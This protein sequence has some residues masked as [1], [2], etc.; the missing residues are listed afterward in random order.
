[1]FLRDDASRGK[2]QGSCLLLDDKRDFYSLH[3]NASKGREREQTCTRESVTAFARARR[4]MSLAPGSNRVPATQ[5]RFIAAKSFKA[6]TLLA[7]YTIFFSFL[8]L[9]R[10]NIFNTKK[11]KTKKKKQK[12]RVKIGI[13]Q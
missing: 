3:S 12:I 5:A 13:Y 11:K 4:S 8:Q 6:T 2:V 1:M 9:A 7:S 10:I